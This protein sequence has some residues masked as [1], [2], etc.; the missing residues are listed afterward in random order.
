MVSAPPCQVG[1][2][3]HFATRRGAFQSCWMSVLTACGPGFTSF[4][5]ELLAQVP[6]IFVSGFIGG[7]ASRV[8]IQ[9]GGR[10]V[11]CTQL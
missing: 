8:R 6:E 11:L 5:G 9:Y 1:A 10:V 2:A 7:R 3:E 4:H